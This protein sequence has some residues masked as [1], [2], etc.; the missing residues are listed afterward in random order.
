VRSGGAPN[1]S[2]GIGQGKAREELLI[3]VTVGGPMVHRTGLMHP[4]KANFLNVSLR[5]LWL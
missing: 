4:R 1:W 5:D 2:S 3:E